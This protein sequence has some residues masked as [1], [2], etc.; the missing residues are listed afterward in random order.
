VLEAMATGRPIITTDAPGCRETVP[1]TERGKR[2]KAAEEPVMEGEN[3]F[4]VRV[5]DVG[6]L[7]KAMRQFIEDTRLIERMGKR[8]RAIAE[9]KY[10]VHK[11]NKMM[12]EAM[13]MSCGLVPASSQQ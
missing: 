4:L 11:V 9:E 5:R 7:E 10:D 6:A 1:L 8:S 2:Q 12:L 13:G 3:G